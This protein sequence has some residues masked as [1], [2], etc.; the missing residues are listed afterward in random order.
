MTKKQFLPKLFLILSL[1][2]CLSAGSALAFKQTT[3]CQIVR[4]AIAFAPSGLQE[5]LVKNFDAVHKGIHHVDILDKEQGRLNPYDA[6]EIYRSLVSSIKAGQLSSY[7]TAHRFGVLASYLAESVNSMDLKHR[8]DMIPGLVRYDGPHR[9]DSIRNS[10]AR[11]I[12]DY[13]NPY[14]GQERR[15]VTDFLYV[16]AVNEIVDHWTDVWL[17][18]GQPIGAFKTAGADLRRTRESELLRGV[19]IRVSSC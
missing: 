18:S 14:Y 16:V 8:R 7:N 12:R 17:R 15:E 11:L 1:I 10:L 6:E 9:I 5:Y 13:H 3:R 19:D 4:D 2:L